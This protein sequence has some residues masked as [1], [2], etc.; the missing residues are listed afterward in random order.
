MRDSDNIKKVNEQ[1]DLLE[2]IERVKI[3]PS[4]FNDLDSLQ[5]KRIDLSRQKDC[6][7]HENSD[8][9][10]GNTYLLGKSGQWYLSIATRN[11]H[12]NGWQFSLGGYYATLGMID[13]LFE[14]TNLPVYENLPRFKYEEEDDEE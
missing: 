12:K 3:F 1:N 7:D 5:L 11:Y 9:I 10:H 13:F 14:V 8:I 6:N 4:Y 2:V